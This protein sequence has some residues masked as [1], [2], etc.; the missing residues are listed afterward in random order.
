MIKGKDY[1]VFSCIS[2]S[3]KPKSA[4]DSQ[5]EAIS[6]AKYINKTYPEDDKK[7]VTYKCN[8]CHQYHLT[9]VEVKKRYYG[10]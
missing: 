9:S 4:W 7:L 2:R 6:N 1:G 10:S 3:G 8:H 5:D